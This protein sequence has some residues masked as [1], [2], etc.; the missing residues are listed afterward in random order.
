MAVGG[1]TAEAGSLFPSR[2][3]TRLRTRRWR[4]LR[5]A[6]QNRPT[7]SLVLNPSLHPMSMERRHSCL[8][9][10]CALRQT[11]REPDSRGGST[12][13]AAA[14]SAW[15]PARLSAATPVS[16]RLRARRC[17]LPV[18]IAVASAKGG[19]GKSTMALLLAS[20]LGLLRTDRIIAV[21]CNPHH[22]TF[23]SR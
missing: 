7:P 6:P 12:N 17:S 8:A 10:T 4:L 19:V 9:S 3:R 13:L 14:E 5:R 22:G 20:R 16:S 11:S 1:G 21:E 2:A 15:A 18:H 23:R